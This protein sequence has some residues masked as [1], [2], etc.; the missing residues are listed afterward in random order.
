MPGPT[1]WP[2]GAKCAVVLTFDLDFEAMHLNWDPENAKRP[3]LLSM[4]LYGAKRAVPEILALLGD[5]GIPG[6]V[7]IPGWVVEHHPETVTAIAKGGHEIGAHGYLH[8]YIGSFPPEEE[9]LILSKSIDIIRQAT[10]KPPA[11]YR[12]PAW[13]FSPNTLRLLDRYGFT[14]S[15]NFMDDIY[16]Y[17]HRREDGSPFLV[18]LP[19]YWDMDGAPFF[20]IP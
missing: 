15:S 9:E 8:E 11:G 17:F 1:K 13:E 16:P 5:Y 7:F 4:G 14:Y 18:E 10:G 19:V 20:R 3:V 6:T 2:N 12:S